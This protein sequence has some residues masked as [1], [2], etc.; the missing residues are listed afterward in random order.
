MLEIP[1]APSRKATISSSL[2]NSFN[3]VSGTSISFDV[4]TLTAT[5]TDCINEGDNT[6]ST[7][8]D[9]A[10][11]TR[12]GVPD[13]GAYEYVDGVDV[14]SMLSGASGGFGSFGGF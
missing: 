6:Y 13:I 9:Y 10:G 2:R 14:G 3:T 5:S 1:E 12:V 7:S 8:Y 4:F 11:T